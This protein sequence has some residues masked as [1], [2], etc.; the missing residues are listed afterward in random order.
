[1]RHIVSPKM[2]LELVLANSIGIGVGVAVSLPPFCCGSKELV[3]CKMDRLM[4]R[5]LSYLQLLLE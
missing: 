1:M 3:P 5:V 2:R 4:I